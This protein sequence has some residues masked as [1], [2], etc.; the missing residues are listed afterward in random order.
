M[1]TFCLTYN[2]DLCEPIIPA[3]VAE[4]D[5]SVSRTDDT[6]EYAHNLQPEELNDENIESTTSPYEYVDTGEYFE[7]DSINIY[8]EIKKI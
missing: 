3:D 1:Q 2:D 4:R 6:Y 5:P 8:F 7:A